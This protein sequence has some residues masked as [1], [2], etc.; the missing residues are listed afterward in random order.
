M[1]SIERTPRKTAQALRILANQIDNGEAPDFGLV[2]YS[3][4]DSGFMTTYR[5]LEDLPGLIGAIEL[6]KM[7]V[8]LEDDAE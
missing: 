8:M 3:P 5:A 1:D 2:I 4:K 7:N 6:L